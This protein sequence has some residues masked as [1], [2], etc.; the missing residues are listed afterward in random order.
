MLNRE[1]SGSKFKGFKVIWGLRTKRINEQIDDL[2]IL[3][4]KVRDV[5]GIEKNFQMKLF[6]QDDMNQDIEE[7]C[8]NLK[9]IKNQTEFSEILKKEED[10]LTCTKIIIEVFDIEKK[11]KPTE[12]LTKEFIKNVLEENFKKIKENEI[13]SNDYFLNVE[14]VATPILRRLG[15]EAEIKESIKGSIASYQILAENKNNGEK[16]L[17]K[18]ENLIE[19]KFNK[20]EERLNN[21]IKSIVD[22][23]ENIN[24][25]QILKDDQN[26]IK[27]EG[28]YIEF[29]NIEDNKE[30]PIGSIFNDTCSICSRSIYFTKYTCCICPNM[31]IC[32]LCENSH[33]HPLLKFKSQ[34]L[35]SKEEVFNFMVSQFT[36]NKP[37]TSSSLIKKVKEISENLFEKKFKLDTYIYSDNFAVRPNKKFKIPVIISN[38]TKEK[39]KYNPNNSKL[40]LM[41]RNNKDLKVTPKLLE[42]GLNSKERCEVFLECE[43]NDQLKIYD[44]EIFLYCDHAKVEAKPLHIKI[45][46]NDD[47]EEEEINDYFA[48]Y[49]KI[50]SIPKNE[51]AMVMHIIKNN[52][53][54]KHP[55]IIYNI[56]VNHG[57]DLEKAFDKLT[58]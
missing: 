36:I 58:A 33:T 11:S 23:S 39:L 20:F 44:L 15:L 24:N 19:S 45:E 52:I 12:Q 55:Y 16:I 25:N 8:G 13:I 46:V 28:S 30:P 14:K 18:I 1:R 32:E 49:L 26:N 47:L 5:H 41:A 34:E 54:S 2:D 57:W 56:M 9:E 48:M 35:C 3:L 42:Y 21:K 29:V 38:S 7:N 40:I 6:Y 37:S 53:S 43:S 4:K 22:N 27:L 51:K 17:N 31:T 50:L 10:K